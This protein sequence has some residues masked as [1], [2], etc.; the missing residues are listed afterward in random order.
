MNI[1][2]IPCTKCNEPLPHN[3]YNTS[4]LEVCPSCGVSIQVDAFPALLK[5]HEEGQSGEDIMLEDESSCFFHPQKRAVIPCDVCGRFLCALCDIEFSGQHICSQC[6]EVGK[7]KRKMKRLETDRVQYDDI[8]LTLAIFPVFL[9]VWPT[10]ITAPISLFIAIRYWRAPLSIVP[11]TK[12]RFILAIFLSSV[13]IIG[14]TFLFLKLLAGMG[15]H[16]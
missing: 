16:I 10:I 8:A 14:W 3:L 9:F 7:K 12:V 11:R 4:S 6:L 2:P 1:Y 13:Q 5:E 15:V